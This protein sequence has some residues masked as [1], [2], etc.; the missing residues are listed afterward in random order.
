MRLEPT[1]H[2]PTQFPDEAQEF[3]GILFRCHSSHIVFGRVT[4]DPASFEVRCI[5]RALI[6]EDQRES[7]NR[8][9][10]LQS[11]FRPIAGSVHQDRAES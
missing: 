7:G 6:P 1:Q 5:V 10:M 3:G 2:V 8:A 11:P 4:F 9:V